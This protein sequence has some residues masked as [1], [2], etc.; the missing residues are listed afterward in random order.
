MYILK[1]FGKFHL[2]IVLIVIFFSLCLASSVWVRLREFEESYANIETSIFEL[3]NDWK[4]EVF[5]RSLQDSNCLQIPLQ[6]QSLQSLLMIRHCFWSL[7]HGKYLPISLRYLHKT[8]IKSKSLYCWYSIETQYTFLYKLVQYIH[9]Q[10]NLLSIKTQI[11]TR[12]ASKNYK[13][14]FNI[15]Q[16]KTFGN[17]NDSFKTH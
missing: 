16:T 10:T 17:W 13:N 11:F 8:A 4:K 6:I 12:Q 9:L 5:S 2:K 15:N 3:R 14:N 7:P 1:K